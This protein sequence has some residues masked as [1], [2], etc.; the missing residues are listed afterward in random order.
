MDPKVSEAMKYAGL[1]SLHIS[2]ELKAGRQPGPKN[3]DNISELE[4]N[5]KSS[6]SNIDNI[7]DWDLPN[8]PSEVP[9]SETMTTPNSVKLGIINFL[10]NAH[11]ILSNL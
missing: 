8:L 1:Q 9:K 7:T 5:S 11:S 6:P 4:V 2:K 10:N 3:N